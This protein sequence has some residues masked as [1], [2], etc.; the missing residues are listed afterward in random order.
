MLGHRFY[1][2]NSRDVANIYIDYIDIYV[3]MKRALIGKR[4]QVTFF[5]LRNPHISTFDLS[6]DGARG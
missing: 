1:Y 5:F 6:V 3:Q 2:L 4:K